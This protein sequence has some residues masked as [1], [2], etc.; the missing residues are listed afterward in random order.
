M[1]DR[2]EKVTSRCIRPVFINGTLVVLRWHFRFEWRDGTVT[3]IEELAYQRW[4]GSRIADE[5]FF[6]DP[7]QLKPRIGGSSPTTE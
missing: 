7:A 6:Y 3:E 5:Q 4:E 1:L 2:A